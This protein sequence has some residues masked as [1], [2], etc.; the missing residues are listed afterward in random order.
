MNW[1]FIWHVRRVRNRP[2]SLQNLFFGS[3]P[4]Y[5]RENTFLREKGFIG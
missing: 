1:A 5:L 4:M 3:H 2:E